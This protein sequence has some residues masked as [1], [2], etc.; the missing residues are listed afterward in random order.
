MYSLVED[1]EDKIAEKENF[2][3]FDE[4]KDETLNKAEILKWV[5]PELEKVADEEAQ[6]LMSETD[7]NKDGQLSAQEILD[8]HELWVGS[9]ATGYGDHDEL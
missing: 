3:Y 7:K 1:E 9:E 8:E 4:D 6:H 2:L 5:S